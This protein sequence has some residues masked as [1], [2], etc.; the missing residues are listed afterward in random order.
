MDARVAKR[1]ARALFQAALKHNI[2]LS[3]EDDL[4]GIQA[5]LHAD[6][7][8]HTFLMNPTIGRGD[9]LQ[10]LES[11]F[12]DRVTALTMQ[13]LRL[14][15]E[16]GREEEYFLMRLEFI[17]L[18][19]DHESVIAAVVTSATPLQDEQGTAIV[20]KLS[21]ET[22]KRVEPEFRVDPALIGGV[23]VAYNDF[24]LDGSIRGSLARLKERLVYDLLKQ[25]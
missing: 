25:S 18:R 23:K 19:R 24:V 21:R 10:L 15:L 9:K 14:L 11:V 2:L 4:N 22:G 8:F 6:A 12:S 5:T 17:R 3:V 13:A 20:E 7:K 16:K 1:Y